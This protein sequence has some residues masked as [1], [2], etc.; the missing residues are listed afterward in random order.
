MSDLKAIFESIPLPVL[1]IACVLL[2]FVVLGVL[3]ALWALLR[4]RKIK[5]ADVSRSPLFIDVEKLD[6]GGPSD[7]VI[8]LDFY[9]LPVR[10]VALV[11]APVGRDRP[12]PALS[13]LP[14]LEEAIVPGLHSIVANHDPEIWVWP[15]QLSVQ[16]FNQAFFN[17]APLPGH[18]G[19][20]SVWCSLAGKFAW[21]SHAFVAG[22]VFRSA[23]P[24]SMGQVE[25]ERE[26]QWLDILRLQR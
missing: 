24:N 19:K 22:M 5:P 21:H 16:G 8:Q 25:A 14:Q 7:Q 13:E 2:G 1:I 15:A 12:V 3:W 9:N 18:Q 23:E 11:I 20:G 17:N 10:M 6:Q 26:T 4:R